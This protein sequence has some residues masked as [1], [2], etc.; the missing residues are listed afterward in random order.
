AWPTAIVGGVGTLGHKAGEVPSGKYVIAV[1]I[2]GAD[3]PNVAGPGTIYITF[4]GSASGNYAANAKIDG[5]VLALQPAL[6]GAAANNGN[7]AVFGLC[8]NNTGRT[9]PGVVPQPAV[10]APIAGNAGGGGPTT[11]ANKYLPANCRP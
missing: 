4:A 11:V 6:S 8:G 3:G 2:G 7:G 9:G 5:K 1:G 10:P